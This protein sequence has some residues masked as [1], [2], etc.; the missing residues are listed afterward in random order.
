MNIKNRNLVRVFATLATMLLVSQISVQ[1]STA[2]TKKGYCPGAMPMMMHDMGEH[3][4]ALGTGVKSEYAGYKLNVLSGK[5]TPGTENTIK[6]NIT[7][8]KKKVV[9]KY[10]LDIGKLSHTIIF[11]S[12]YKTYIHKHAEVDKKGNFSMSVN[13]P[14]SGSYHMIVDFAVPFAGDKVNKV[15]HLVLG[16]EIVVGSKSSFVKQTPP[17]CTVNTSGYKI[18]LDRT[19]IPLEHDT[20]MITLTKKGQPVLL[21]KYLGTV[22][23]LVMIKE[24]DRSYAHM[25]P[26]NADGSM[27]EMYSDTVDVTKVDTTKYTD[28]NGSKND[29]KAFNPKESNPTPGMLH[30]MTEPPG[31]GRYTAYLQFVDNGKLQ[32]VSFTIDAK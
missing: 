16:Q 24:S 17:A 10:V 22:A 31:A 7:D 23:H 2:A 9:T 3:P 26:M 30:F 32:T 15:A 8:S 4:H 13:L 6:Y 28:K 27:G 29:I 1:Y 12:D 25:H 21:G 14:Q 5:L 18:A 20:L 19:T 11:S